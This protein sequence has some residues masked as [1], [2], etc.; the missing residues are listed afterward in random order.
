[1]KRELF[2]L[3]QEL[4]RRSPII[5]FFDDVHWADAS[6]VDLLAYIGAHGDGLC[7]LTIATYRPSELFLTDHPFVGLKRELQARGVCE[8]IA[9]G[10][11]ERKDISSYLNLEFPDHAFPDTLVDLLHARTDGSPLFMVN[12]IR[13]LQD[14]GAIIER[15]G[16]RL[17]KS[18]SEI[19]KEVPESIRSMIERKI[20][21]L[22]EADRHL[23]IV[24]S[25]QGLEFHA[26]VVA[27]ALEM[28]E[29][30]IEES[31]ERLDQVHSFVRR[32]GEEEMPD[33]SLTLRYRFVHALYQNALYETLTPTRRTQLSGVVANALLRRH[34]TDLSAVAGELA[35]LFEVAREF[36]HASD[37]FLQAAQKAIRV[38][39]NQEAVGLCRRSIENAK[40]LEGNDKETR[41]VAAALELAQLHINISGFD[42]AIESFEMAEPAAKAAGM[43]E[44]RIEAIC[45][46]S[47]CSYYNKRIDE[48]RADGE[49][50]LELA[51]SINWAQGVASA[52]LRIASQHVCLGE[53][54]AAE[55][56]FARAVP[57]LQKGRLHPQAFDSVILSGA[58]HVWRQEYDDA[59]R[60]L[61][62]VKDKA[63][64]AGSGFAIVGAHFF[65]SIALGNQGKLGEAIESL[66]EGRRLAELNQEWYWR[67]RLPNTMAWLHRELGDPEKSH[68]LNLESVRLAREVGW[69]EAEANAHVNLAIDYMD[70]GEPARAHESLQKAE[71]IF[72]E[73]IWYRWRYNIRL[74]AAFARY[75]I[76]QGDLDAAREYAEASEEAARAH[77]DRK[78]RAW[79]RK[80]LGEIALLLDDVDT[81]RTCLDEAIGILAGHPCPTIGWKILISRAELAAQLGDAKPADEFRGRARATIRS[82]ADSLTDDG[83]KTRFLKSPGVR[84]V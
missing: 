67:S 84:R 54:D 51:R 37:S 11:L 79:A 41:V 23:L 60:I 12:V 62:F 26:A 18:F 40:K 5:L 44:E 6:T 82:L 70:L 15:D 33:G 83:L 68:L 59:N 9:L 2:T 35:L 63:R 39:A 52:E 32:V 17:V 49:R 4:S 80:T 75:W 76:L 55:P 65:H 7:L 58:V 31:L 21:Q 66:T 14:T 47:M 72:D 10:F 56:L 29:A 19:E 53:I 28:D 24:A 43:N 74:K 69:L 57:V 1:M 73:D 78:Y 38:C 20:D 36:A 3:I 64:E 34:S 16:W 45:G 50:A 61:K 30:E 42:D 46:R 27:G 48:A 8:E 25:V 71:S 77:G 81:S 22:D 13:Y